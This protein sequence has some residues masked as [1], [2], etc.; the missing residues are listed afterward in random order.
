M[1]YKTIL[2]SLNETN[3]ENQILSFAV[4]LAQKF[5]SHVVGLYVIPAVQLYPSVGYE[6]VPQVFDGNQV[7]FKDQEKKVRDTFE[8]KMKAEGVSSE[9]RVVNGATPSISDEVVSAGRAADLIIISTTN[10]EEP[11]GVES[12]F[13]EQVVMSAG[14]PVIALPTAGDI[15][16]D[17]STVVV[18]WNGGREASRAAF[19]AMP[20]LKAG[21][22]VIIMRADPQ[23]DATLRGMVPSADLAETLARHGVKAEAMSFPTSSGEAGQAVLTCASDNGAGLMV[24]GAYGHSRLREFIFGGATQHVLANLNRPVL[25]SH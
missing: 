17:L 24:M 6:A 7:F 13:V 4:A 1:A 12:D 2:V 20:I 19:D 16:L 3:R 5:K 23:K 15:S 8:A 9:F 22:R 11:T 21:K 25:M 14:R 18:G 10:P